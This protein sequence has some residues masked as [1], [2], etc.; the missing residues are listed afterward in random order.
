V[1]TRFNPSLV[2]QGTGFLFYIRI[3]NVRKKRHR[4]SFGCISV[5]KEGKQG[6]NKLKRG[7]IM[8]IQGDIIS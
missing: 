2:F 4:K 8:D 7:N 3:K 6:A 1:V 5:L